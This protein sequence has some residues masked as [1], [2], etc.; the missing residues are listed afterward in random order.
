MSGDLLGHTF[1]YY[2]AAIQRLDSVNFLVS[3]QPAYSETNGR[4]ARSASPALV[5]DTRRHLDDVG[6]GTEADPNRGTPASI[7]DSAR[8]RVAQARQ[9]ARSVNVAY[10]VS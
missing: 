3:S 4:V 9:V 5:P 8:V 1:R 2:L 10:H 7:P 6:S